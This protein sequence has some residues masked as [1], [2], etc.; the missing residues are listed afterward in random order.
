MRRAGK[1]RYVCTEG[2]FGGAI[3]AAAMVAVAWIKSGRLEITIEAIVAFVVGG[4]FGAAIARRE[5]N[6][7]E[8][9]YPDIGNDQ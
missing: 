8:S 9:I 5:W 4:L 2:L 6:K 3:V 7:F 1:L